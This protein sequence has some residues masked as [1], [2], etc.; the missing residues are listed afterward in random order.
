[1]QSYPK[2][3][4][5]EPACWDPCRYLHRLE[6]RRWPWRAAAPQADAWS[7]PLRHSTRWTGGTSRPPL[8]AAGVRRGTSLLRWT[9]GPSHA[10]VAHAVGVQRTVVRPG[11]RPVAG[12]AVGWPVGRSWPWRHG[13]FA[14]RRARSRS[15]AWPVN[16]LLFAAVTS[17]HGMVPNGRDSASRAGAWPRLT[18]NPGALNRLAACDTRAGRVDGPC[19]ARTRPQEGRACRDPLDREMVAHIRPLHR[20]GDQ[21]RTPQGQDVTHG[22]AKHPRVVRPCTPMQS[23]WMPPVEPWCSLLH[24]TR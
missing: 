6:G 1:M 17:R 11:A 8:R 22:F 15:C 21:V 5:G 3:H 18:C 9:A 7:C 19:A 10:Y 13:R 24:R 16:A 20:V 12:A 23:S 14:P 4:D 2:W